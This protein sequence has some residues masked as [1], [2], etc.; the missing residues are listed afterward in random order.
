TFLDPLVDAGRVHLDEPAYLVRGEQRI[1]VNCLFFHVCHAVRF[2]QFMRLPAPT[3]AYDTNNPANQANGPLTPRPSVKF[4][5]FQA[6]A[7][8]TLVCTSSAP[9]SLSSP[10]F[11]PPRGPTR[12]NSI[13]VRTRCRFARP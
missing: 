5:R 1:R 13:P 8:S 11:A 2:H 3:Q 6:V 7:V 12:T 4:W 10:S 9:S